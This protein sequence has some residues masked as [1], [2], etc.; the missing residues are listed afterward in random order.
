MAGSI[1]NVCYVWRVPFLQIMRDYHELDET[2]ERLGDES[3]GKAVPF[4]AIQKQIHR[5]NDSGKGQNIVQKVMTYID[6]HYGEMITRE[7]LGIVAC[8]N[9]TYLARIFKTETGKS[10]GNYILDERIKKAK[11]LLETSEMTIS[12]VAQAVGYDN[13][14]YFSK[15]FKDRTGMTPKEYRKGEE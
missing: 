5:N 2:D 3:K 10:M 8:L 9:P 1:L 7:Q 14:S 13:F 12:E 4:S 15:L 6:Q 11:L